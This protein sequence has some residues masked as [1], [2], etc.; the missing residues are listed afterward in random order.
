MS[1]A[2]EI[3][4]PAGFMNTSHDTFYTDYIGSFHQTGYSDQITDVH[5]L[6][7][8]PMGSVP[9]MNIIEH[10]GQFRMEILACCDF[11]AYAEAMAEAMK[12]FGLSVTTMPEWSFLT[13]LTNWRE[14]MQITA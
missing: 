1:Y 12:G 7:K 8:P 5:F 4:K 9:H 13:P 14:G 3:K 6:C 10:D 11:T 2:E